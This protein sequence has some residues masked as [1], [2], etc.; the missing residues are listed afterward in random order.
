MIRKISWVQWL[1]TVAGLIF[2]VG[3]VLTITAGKTNLSS[4]A[5]PLGIVML[6]AGSINIF[7]NFKKRQVIHGAHLLLADGM[8]TALLSVFLL[9][10]RSVEAGQMPFFFGVWELFSGIL[11]AI[12]AW[13]LRNE[14]LRGWRRFATVGIVEMVSGV[15]ALLKPIDDFV[16]MHIVVSVILFI[17]GCSFIFKVMLYPH[18][19]DRN[20]DKGSVENV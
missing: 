7:I 18:I 17:Q 12:D 2:F 13:E 9:F 10:N 3:S 4:L 15:S 8:A 6:T 1:W 11:K 5:I 14:G 20:S 19:A 16:G